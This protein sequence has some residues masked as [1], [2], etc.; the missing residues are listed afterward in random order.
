MTLRGS[1]PRLRWSITATHGLST[2]S[3]LAPPEVA[4]G[5]RRAA[6]AGRG[7]RFHTRSS[8]K[9]DELLRGTPS[10]LRQHSLDRLGHLITDRNICRDS[11]STDR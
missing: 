11:G 7:T 9:P 3:F 10:P 5:A 1:T 6:H 8:A 2:A 4:R